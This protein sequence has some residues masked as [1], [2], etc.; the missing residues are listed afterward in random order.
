MK[1]VGS[2]A[3]TC[4]LVFLIAMV[5]VIAV[6]KFFGVKMLTVMGSSMEPTI[7][8]G[9]LIYVFPTDA[10]NIKVG[11]VISFVMNKELTVATHRVVSID[12]DQKHFTTKGDANSGDDGKV[13]YG[14]VL[15]VARI[16]VPKV[17]YLM[18]FFSTVK[19]RIL[20]GALLMGLILTA[21]FLSD[22]KKKTGESDDGD[23]DETDGADQ[24]D[25]EFDLIPDDFDA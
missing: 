21:F 3:S 4:L 13:A 10:E 17:G 1:K 24:S 22:D 19:G 9:D 23:P 16:T 18:Y 14:N 7:E 20:G 12:D 2:V 5:A 15:G 25:D 8:A 11:D 6:P